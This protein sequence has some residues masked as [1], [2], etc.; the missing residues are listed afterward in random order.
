MCRYESKKVRLF[1]LRSNEFSVKSC[2]C[3]AAT[4]T[5]CFAYKSTILWAPAYGTQE[6]GDSTRAVVNS[7]M[8]KRDKHIV[9]AE[10]E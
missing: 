10:G 1:A 2:V 5:S 8:I 9:D 6:I 3:D 7:E 4:C